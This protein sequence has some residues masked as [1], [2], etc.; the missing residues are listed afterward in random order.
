[1]SEAVTRD[2]RRPC[3]DWHW[4]ECD[5][6]SAGGPCP[7]DGREHVALAGHERPL[8]LC[9]EHA[10][11]AKASDDYRPADNGHQPPEEAP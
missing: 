10:A 4:I 2:D 1:M 3:H 5:R 7:R 6:V 9:Q 8:W 11:E